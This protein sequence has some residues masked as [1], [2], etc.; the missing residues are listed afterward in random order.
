PSTSCRS[1]GA[2]VTPGRSVG[3]ARCSPCGAAGGAS[4]AGP[5]VYD[6][7]TPGV[8]PVSGRGRFPRPAA[9]PE[10][11]APES[12]GRPL[13]PASV[14]RGRPST[15]AGCLLASPHRAGAG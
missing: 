6:P 1:G 14:L 4:T 11:L 5:P 8:A 12:L 9:P 7:Q 13:T 15:R 3:P 2:V 10:R